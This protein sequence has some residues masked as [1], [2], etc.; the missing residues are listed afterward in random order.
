VKD[1]LISES[2]TPILATDADADPEA[3]AGEPVLPRR[4][5]WRGAEHVVAEVLERWKEYSSGSPAMPDR[6]LR[7]HWY[8]VRTVAGVEM[9]LYFERKAR[10]KGQAKRRWWLFSVRDPE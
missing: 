10:S 3:L 1:R 6:Y 9:T 2:I 4:F 8:R 5:V 7:K